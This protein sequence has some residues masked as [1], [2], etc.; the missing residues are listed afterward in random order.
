MVYEMDP[1]FDAKK[2]NEIIVKRLSRISPSLKQHFPVVLQKEK[3]FWA[4]ISEAEYLMIVFLTSKDENRI[5][6][7]ISK[8]LNPFP[9]LI[10]TRKESA[11]IR[12]EKSRYMLLNSCSISN[13]YT[14]SLGNDST[15]I[16]ENHTQSIDTQEFGTIQYRVPLAYI[17]SY[18]DEI[19]K[20]TVYEYFDGLVA[21]STNMWREADV[22]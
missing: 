3:I 8:N 14:F 11:A 16:L 15:I 21:Y 9:G 7:F 22:K 2:I 18:G 10:T 13:S 12:A 1:D 20:A 17:I 6:E 19:N 4:T 5:N